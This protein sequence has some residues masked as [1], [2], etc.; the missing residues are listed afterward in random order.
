[1]IWF[2]P[3]TRKYAYF[4]W[5]IELIPR[6]SKHIKFPST[7][8]RDTDTP[9]SPVPGGWSW[10]EDLPE[11]EAISEPV[12]E[13]ILNSEKHAE[14]QPPSHPEDV[15]SMPQTSGR[16][17][18]P[19]QCRICLEQVLPTFHPPNEHLPAFLAGGYVNY[20]SESGHLIRP[21]QCK[22][23]SRYV[24][25][26]CLEQWRHSD[27][28]YTSA[29]RYYNCPTCGFNYRVERLTWA[30]YISSTGMYSAVSAWL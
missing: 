9:G 15:Q 5:E 14:D 2:S 8:S 25:E 10:P 24:H 21:C 20:E 16:H 1:V 7:M 6:H 26:Q 13:S 12:E 17:W 18:R 3:G 19:R 29:R 23:S 30:R 11:Y 28:S 4:K 27:R 22:G